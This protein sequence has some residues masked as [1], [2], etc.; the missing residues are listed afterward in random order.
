MIWCVLKVVNLVNKTR[1]KKDP[2]DFR[3]Y[4]KTSNKLYTVLAT[5]FYYSI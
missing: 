2:K 4:A 5:V 3:K 1:T